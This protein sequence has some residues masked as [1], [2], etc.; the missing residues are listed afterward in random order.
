MRSLAWRISLS[1]SNFD[2]ILTMR[3]RAPF[4]AVIS[5]LEVTMSAGHE[6]AED[7]RI[8]EGDGYIVCYD[9][10]DVTRLGELTER[11]AK[12][13]PGETS[14]LDPYAA[15]LLDAVLVAGF[16]DALDKLVKE[17]DI[18]DAARERG[19]YLI[20]VLG[21]DLTPG[22]AEW[23][24]TGE[25]GVSSINALGAMTGFPRDTGTAHPPDMS[26]FRLC[27]LLLDAAPEYRDR[28]DRVAELSPVWAEIV[29]SWD[30]IV[31]LMERDAPEWRDRNHIQDLKDTDAHR[32]FET[33]LA[34][35]LSRQEEMKP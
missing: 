6:P 13:R 34:A 19:N 1:R 15:Q 35:G 24:C 7:P 17:P 20:T 27:A 25:H 30:E 26:G 9:P 29:A 16:R 14:Y 4:R 31:E 5:M 32:R 33:A 22:A 10:I 3:G 2:L 8:E 11:I 28:L 23:W 21:A 18:L 12:Q